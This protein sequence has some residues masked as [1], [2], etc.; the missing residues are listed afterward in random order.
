MSQL[1]FGVATRD[2][3][4]AFPAW[5]HGY[6]TRSR[7]SA[8]VTERLALGCLAVSNGAKTVLLI[9]CDFIGITTPVCNE[10]Y[11]L[12]QQE[13]GLTWPDVMLACSHT[14]WAPGL[15]TDGFTGVD[16]YFQE[17]DPRYV[18]DFQAKLV[19]AAKESLRNLKPGQLETARLAVPQVLYNRRTVSKATG[20]VKMNFLYPENPAEYTLSPADSQLTVLRIR[21]E[22]G[23]RAVLM[24]F[25]CHPVTSCGDRKSPQDA[26][27]A[28]YPY[29]VRETI[30]ARYGCPVFFTLGAAG[31]AV[32]LD[33]LG[34]S[35]A[36]IGGILGNSAILAERM[37]QADDSAA[38]AT[39]GI[40]V[41]IETLLR[42]DPT[43]AE[44]AFAKLMAERGPRL[45]DPQDPTRKPWLGTPEWDAAQ[46]VLDTV[47]RSRLYPGHRFAAPLQFIRLGSTVLSALPFEV[48]SEISL[49]MKARYPHS[50]L[51]SCAGGY[52]GYL[53]LAHEFKRGG[54]EVSLAGSH[55]APGS[56]DRILQSVLEKLE[57]F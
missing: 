25:G 57:S 34:D 46:D 38:L 43:A 7:P 1:H 29:Y 37:F 9:S 36:R 15:H 13:V 30:T 28:D 56:G 5:L 35:R 14:H 44:K 45:D 41:E 11:R 55:F 4:P 21:D 18:A 33:R 49:T 24:N 53:A 39:A 10:L 27:S 40:T 47:S 16:G 42:S 54:F 20:N 19:E 31:D 8:G 32:P 12:L 17:P 50:V 23:I 51:V 52:H 26:V 3:T 22:G 48:L 6:G 2:I